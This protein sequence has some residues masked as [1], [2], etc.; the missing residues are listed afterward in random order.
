[1]AIF[2]LPC[3]APEVRAGGIGHLHVFPAR[4]G[5]TVRPRVLTV[6][7]IAV[8]VLVVLCRTFSVVFYIEFCLM[9]C[10][11]FEMI[12]KW[13]SKKKIW[14]ISCISFA[15]ILRKKFSVVLWDQEVE[16]F[17]RQTRYD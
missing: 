1:M 17:G 6:Q 9:F 8:D 12:L 3:L 15:K 10:S 4:V 11:V 5:G 14:K 16:A 7:C 2:R 13:F